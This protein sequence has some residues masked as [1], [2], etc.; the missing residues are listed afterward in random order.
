MKMVYPS[1]FLHFLFQPGYSLSFDCTHY[2]RHFHCSDKTLFLLSSLI[3]R[4]VSQG[5]RHRLSL[6]C[7]SVFTYWTMI[8][9]YHIPLTIYHLQASQLQIA[10]SME[11]GDKRCF[12]KQNCKELR[13]LLLLNFIRI[14]GKI[15]KR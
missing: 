11:Y 7:L 2:L 5:H 12:T 13:V 15:R 8:R 6:V 9:L 4:D 14:L 10:S 3:E 1:A